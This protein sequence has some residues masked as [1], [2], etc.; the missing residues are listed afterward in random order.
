VTTSGYLRH[1]SRDEAENQSA[2]AIDTHARVLLATYGPLMEAVD[3]NDP[4]RASQE[5]AKL[6]VSLRNERRAA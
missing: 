3:T 2:C 5:L 4:D 1:W 6:L